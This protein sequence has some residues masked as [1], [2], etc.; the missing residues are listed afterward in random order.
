L[1]LEMSTSEFWSASEANFFAT[2][3]Q[4]FA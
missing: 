1:D 4:I 2:L 3:K